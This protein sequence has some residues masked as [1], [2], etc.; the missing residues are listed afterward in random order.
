MSCSPFELKD[1]VLGELRPA[2]NAA[3]EE[4]VAGCAA[5]RQELTALRIT[6]NALLSV[7]DEDPPRRIA[8]VS[9][10]VFEPRWWRKLWRSGPQLGFASAAMLSV[11]LV[12]HAFVPPRQA[13]PPRSQNADVSPAVIE[14]AVE[15]EVA[16]RA[17]DLVRK[18]VAESEARQS[19]KLL[20]F[21]N[22]RL[23]LADQRHREDLLAI[24]EVFERIQ[25]NQAMVRKAA[26]QV[27]NQ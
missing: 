21:V 8:F 24:K 15:A 5:C 3:V 25:K 16:R 17:A 18:A 9:D 7:A 1:Y 26:Y 6:Q 10:K 11:A 2:E 22:A 13:P 14:K 19:A 27:I 23:R 12:V 4:H 20:E